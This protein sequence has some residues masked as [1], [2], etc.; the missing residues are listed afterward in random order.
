MRSLMK[1]KLLAVIAAAVLAMWNT[2]TDAQT[3]ELAENGGPAFWY[4]SEMTCQ[5]CGRVE[6]YEGNTLSCAMSFEDYQ[7]LY[8]DWRI[9]GHETNCICLCPDCQ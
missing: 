3:K 8:P 9:E 1:F 5:K 7:I 4:T 2:C 6:R